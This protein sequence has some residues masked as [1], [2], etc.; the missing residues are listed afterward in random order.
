M[1][2]YLT[3]FQLLPFSKAMSLAQTCFWIQWSHSHLQDISQ[4]LIREGQETQYPV[5]SITHCLALDMCHASTLYSVLVLCH[6]IM[7]L[8]QV[9][10]IHS[11]NKSHIPNPPR[12][13]CKTSLWIHI[14]NVTVVGLRQDLF[15][16]Y[17]S[18]WWCCRLLHCLFSSKHCHS[19][20][21]LN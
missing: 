10:N 5:Q 13:L 16:W 2:E 21:L 19:C 14:V 11:E 9:I 8:L 3:I 1:D 7:L 17:V 12:S 18:K 4:H 6:H 20:S 15:S